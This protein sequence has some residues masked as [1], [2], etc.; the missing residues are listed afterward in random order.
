MERDADGNATSYNFL[1]QPGYEVTSV[2]LDRAPQVGTWDLYV[3]YTALD[4]IDHHLCSPGLI[5]GTTVTVT[6]P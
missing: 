2:H 1:I 3:N 5:G 6:E 4:T